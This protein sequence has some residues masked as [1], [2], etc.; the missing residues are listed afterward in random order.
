ML[1][2]RDV[3]PR[4]PT[5]IYIHPGSNNSNKRGGEKIWVGWGSEIRKNLSRIRISNSVA[6]LVKFLVNLIISSSSKTF[7]HIDSKKHSYRKVDLLLELLK[8]RKSPIFFVIKN[9]LQGQY[10]SWLPRAYL[11]FY[12]IVEAE[13]E[14]AKQ[15]YFYFLACSWKSFSIFAKI[16]CNNIR[17]LRKLTWK[18]WRKLT[19]VDLSIRLLQS[20]LGTNCWEYI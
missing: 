11:N 19:N 10:H 4:S 5:L 20:N 14:G 18:Y 3:F 6:V 12:S 16:M 1:R 9:I 2:G 7:W 13:K 8:S 17:K 15:Y